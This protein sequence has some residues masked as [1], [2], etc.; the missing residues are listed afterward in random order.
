MW[1]VDGY[2]LRRT[3]ILDMN[4]L[5]TLRGRQERPQPG[6]N[7]ADLDARAHDREDSGNIEAGAT[8][9]SS[10]VT[11]LLV[12][13]AWRGGWC[14]R[15]VADTLRR[16]GHVVYAPTLTGVGE[17][18]HLSSERVSLT[19]H[20]MDVVNEVVWKELSNI[21]LCGHSY[22]GMVITAALEHIYRRV[23]SVVYLDAF[24]PADGQS[25]YDLTGEPYPPTPLMVPPIPAEVFNVNLADR[26]WMDAQA[27]PQWSACFTERV[28]L[29]GARERV[30]RKT[31][32]LAGSFD[33]PAFR[34][35]HDRLS[36][37]RSWTTRIIQGGHDVM[38]DNPGELADALIDAAQR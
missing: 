6:L 13:G 38:I 34:A 32:L 28:S 4:H 26:A 27:T 35:A 36:Q 15:R 30:P 14:W 7:A 22:G 31:Y 1:R 23:S 2:Q 29:T 17:R 18:S 16:R 20:A 10:E 37:D 12:H 33:L 21:V 11:F 9:V 8:R 25:L 19:T 24:F 3:L 5:H